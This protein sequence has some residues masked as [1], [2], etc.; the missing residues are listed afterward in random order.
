MN[1][2]KTWSARSKNYHQMTTDDTVV[3]CSFPEV[4]NLGDELPSTA[5]CYASVEVYS[6]ENGMER[7]IAMA[8]GNHKLRLLV[9]LYE[10][11]FGKK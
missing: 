9:C 11:L 1:A 2:V 10:G 5:F 8:E 6:V 7:F 4:V 3:I